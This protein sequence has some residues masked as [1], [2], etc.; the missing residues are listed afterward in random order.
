MERKTKTYKPGVIYRLFKTYLRFIH[1]KL[2]Y[3][4]TYCI[5]PENIPADGT[6]LMIVSNHQNC[7]NDPLGI[8]F[9]IRDRKPNFITR[10]DIFTIHPL[11]QKFL[12]SIGLLPSF[13]INYEGEEALSNNKEMFRISGRELVNGRTIVL[14]PEAGHQDKHWLGEFSLGYTKLAFEAAELHNFETDIQILPSCNHYSDYYHVQEQFLVKFG[15]PVS[16]QPFYELYKN[17]PRTAQRQVN[18]LVRKQIEGLMLNI[19]DLDNYQSIDFLR[20]TYGKKYAQRNG[21]DK[22]SLPDRLISD[23][24]FV[25]DLEQAKT[26]SEKAI[27][28]TYKGALALEKGIKELKINDQLFDKTP[29]GSYIILQLIAYAILFPLWIFSL[30]PNALNFVLPKLIINR[31]TDKLF[32]GTFVYALSSILTIPIF[33]ALSFI[34]ICIYINI[35]SALIYIALLPL[36]GLFAWYYRKF[37]IQTCQAIRFRSN[38]GTNRLKDLIGLRT[39]IYNQLDT[40][41]EGIK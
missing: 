1:D 34:L 22:E 24:A 41:L 15:T 4:H 14:F 10:G 37:F 13:R 18:A 35:L 8:L 6:P 36:L 25:K 9:A 27:I 29:S 38:L 16:I 39:K 5:N 12:L 11:I 28:D 21:L 26:K 19:E 3:R 20:N 23:K 32:Y 17:K 33:Y 30:W 2:Y 40:L 31:M 7:L